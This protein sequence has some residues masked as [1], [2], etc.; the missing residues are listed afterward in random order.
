MVRISLGHEGTCENEPNS[1]CG[2]LVYDESLPALFVSMLQRSHGKISRYSAPQVA[3]QVTVPQLVDAVDIVIPAC[4]ES[5]RLIITDS[6]A[7]INRDRDNGEL[8]YTLRGIAKNAPWVRRIFILVNGNHKLKDWVPQPEKT[9][10]VNRCALFPNTADCPSRNSFAVMSVVH[11]IPNLA[12][13]FIY[14]EDDMLLM[15]PTT[16]QN[17]YEGGLP[18]YSS[19]SYG[20][21]ELYHKVANTG[22]TE[23]EVPKKIANTPGVV[24]VWVPLTKTI[25]SQIEKEYPK[26]YEFVR[27]HSTGRYDSSLNQSGTKASDSTNSL[28]EHFEGVWW[29]WMHVHHAGD[30]KSVV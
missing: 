25:A 8:K 11:R 7:M 4:M 21:T 30:R 16:V 2:A 1:A 9:S 15:Q 10:M 18:R 3:M 24:H 12:E 28:E 27:S 19:S 29:W 13:H 17:F 5:D 14:V 20:E 22:L 23:K 6:S 26:W